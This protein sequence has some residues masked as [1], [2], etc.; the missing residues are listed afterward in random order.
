V[1]VGNDFR[2]LLSERNRLPGI[3]YYELSDDGQ[4]ILPPNEQKKLIRYR[5]TR[6]KNHQPVFVNLTSIIASHI[7]TRAAVSSI[8]QSFLTRRRSKSATRDHKTISQQIRAQLRDMGLDSFIFDRQESP[9]AELAFTLAEKLFTE[10]KNYCEANDIILRVVTIPHA[11]G[12][13]F[14]YVKENGFTWTIQNWN[15]AG[16]E[17]RMRDMFF[18]LHIPYLETGL[19][20]QTLDVDIDTIKSMRTLGGGHFT[21]FGHEFYA[22]MISDV[23]YD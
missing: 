20:L 4:L 17:R 5:K 10:M 2:N 16:P 19:R 21:E 12:A 22:A 7:L 15:F 13:W 3:W 6:E 18:K 14:A 8:R 23:F 9:D 11:P 1:F